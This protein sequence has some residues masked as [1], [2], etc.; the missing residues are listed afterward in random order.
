MDAGG[1]RALA[2]YA[3]REA[4]PL[5]QSLCA[6]TFSILQER[7]RLA[8][9]VLSTDD[10]EPTF[11]KGFPYFARDKVVKKN[12]H[13][14]MDALDAWSTV[15]AKGDLVESENVPTPDQ[16]H[17]WRSTVH[18][19]VEMVEQTNNQLNDPQGS[20]IARELRASHPRVFA[21]EATPPPMPLARLTRTDVPSTY[22]D[23]PSASVQD[24][25]DVSDQYARQQLAFRDQDEHL[26]G[27][28]TS[29]SRQHHLSLRMNEEL[30]LHTNLLDDL[31]RG[32]DDT[33][34]RLGGAS[35]RMDR[36]RATMN[37]HGRCCTLTQAHCGS[38][39]C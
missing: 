37:E 3:P 39:L 29:I 34:L 31:D 2:S 4:T 12:L 14:L 11:E 24:D 35:N 17:D 10:T 30:E 38:S 13:T 18:H 7:L 21:E 36:F 16:L 28:T 1:R 6:S 25:A 8:N 26:D 32:V 5:F 9:E 27:L 22:T 15:H 23:I 19:L 33:E 20:A